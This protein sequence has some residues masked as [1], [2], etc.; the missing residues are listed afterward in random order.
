M[1]IMSRRKERFEDVYINEEW[2]YADNETRSGGGSTVEINKFRAKFLASFI[3]DYQ[4]TALYDI[5][6]DANWQHTIDGLEK[7]R[8]LGF[9]ISETALAAAK[10]K[11]RVRK[12]MVFSDRSIDLC[13]EL[14]EVAPEDRKHSLVLVK[15]VIQHLPL[16]D[17]LKLLR[18]IKRSGIQYI[19][20]TNHSEDLF[21]ARENV[22]VATGGF[23]PNNMFRPPFNFK[24]PT[25]D[26]NADI[27][28]GLAGGY[29]N[30]MI[31]N[32]DEQ[33]IERG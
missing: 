1:M 18:N 16:Q 10:H 31:F 19:A 13:E 11:N 22:N 17:G 5:C 8:Y 9:D 24:H 6:G 27:P 3:R 21:G 20:I 30:L 25:R 23:Y 7:I 28:A 14:L 26:V 33:D 2:G 15:E 12:H 29:G 32:M 4:V